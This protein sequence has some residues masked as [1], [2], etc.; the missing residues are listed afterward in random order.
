MARVLEKGDI[1]FVFRPRVEDEHPHGLD[2]VQR[3]FLVLSPRDK[4]IYRRIVVGRKRLPDVDA[5]ERVWAYVDKVA[6]RPE[7]VEQD[8]EAA[9]YETKTRGERHLPAARPAGAGV[10]AI[11]SHNRHVHLAY[12][13]E[14]PKEPGE[15]Q[16]ALD[17]EPRGSFIATIPNPERRAGRGVGLP[18][19][20]RAELPKRLMDRFGERRFLPL[21]PDFLDH[22]GTELVL[23]GAGHEPDEELDLDL[24]P[25]NET[26][27]T[28]EIFNDLKMERDRHPTRPLLEGEWA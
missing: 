10:Y 27:Q 6:R 14:L 8:F 17:I 11:A 3:F 20:R 28:A 19:P 4:P 22:E 16:E 21:D 5:R 26:D 24:Q 2:D 9:T 23:I 18:S 12:E 25:E 7:P 13:L 1:Y 15:V